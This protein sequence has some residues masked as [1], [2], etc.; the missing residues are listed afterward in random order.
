MAHPIDSKQLKTA[1]LKAV[2]AA[3][4]EGIDLKQT[5]AK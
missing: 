3:K 1:R 5:Y 4:A 2:E